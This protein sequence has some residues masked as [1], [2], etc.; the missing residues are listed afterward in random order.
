MTVLNNIEIKHIH[1]YNK[2]TINTIYCKKN[3]PFDEKDIPNKRDI[4][5]L[6]HLKNIPFNFIN[7]RVGILIGVNH[8]HILK[9]LEVVEGYYNQPYA[10]RYKQGWS[11]IREKERIQFVRIIL[12]TE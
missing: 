4:Q 9:P 11:L 7:K 12:V 6:S 2:K 8:A 3:W 10:I 1:G 5:N